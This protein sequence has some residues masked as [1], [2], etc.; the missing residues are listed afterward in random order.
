MFRPMSC[1]S[2]P[3]PRSCSSSSRRLGWSTPSPRPSYNPSSQS[4]RVRILFRYVN[5]VPNM[6]QYPLKLFAVG[7]PQCARTCTGQR[8]WRRCRIHRRLT[9]RR[10]SRANSGS[11]SQHASR[12]WR[13]A[14]PIHDA[15][16]TTAHGISTIYA[17][18]TRGWRTVSNA[19][20][21]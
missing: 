5:G 21:G 12:R 9:R 16:T 7:M 4:Q 20:T 2:S 14:T 6:V 13:Y 11:P 8:E 15:R 3:A 1:P 10:K 18:T 17:N 19:P